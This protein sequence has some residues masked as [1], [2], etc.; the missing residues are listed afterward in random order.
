[1]QN[2]IQQLI[3]NA[4]WFFVALFMFSNVEA[5]PIK[6]TDSL[7][8]IVRNSKNDSIKVSVLNKLALHYV[9]SDLSKAKDFQEQSEQLA[10]SKKNA[11]GYNEA[12]FI[13]GG[14]FVLSGNS[15]SAYVYYKKGYDLALKNKFKPIE[16]R[17][18]NGFGLI[19]W[20]KGNHDKALNYFF[21]ALKLNESLAEEQRVNSSLFYNNIGLIYS[22][23]RLFQK[24]LGYIQK[25]YKIRL[26]DKMVREQAMSLN[27][28]GICYNNLKKTD[29][30]IAAFKKGISIARQTNNMMMYYKIIHNLGNLYADNGQYQKAI[31]LYL[32]LLEQPNSL[33][34][35]PRDLIILYGCIANTY[36]KMGDY[37]DS[38]KYASLG[39]KVVKFNP[40][41]ERWAYVLYNAVSKYYF[42]KGDIA[43]GDYY[44]IKYYTIIKNTFTEESKTTLAE[45]EAKY[46]A[47]KR[48]KLWIQ[49]KAAIEKRNLELQN[50]NA[51]YIIFFLLAIGLLVITYLLYYQQKLKNKQQKQEFKLKNAIAQVNTQNK[52]QEQRIQ[53]SRDLHDNIGSQLTFII[54]SIDS[55]KYAFEIQNSKL[56]DKL[57][58]ISDFTRSTITELRDTIWAMNK[59]EIQFE[60]L[61]ARILSFIEN[62]KIASQ[63]ISFQFNIHTESPETAFSATEGMNIY[64][65]LQEAINNAIKHAKA[66]TILVDVYQETDTFRIQISDNGK[67]FENDKVGFGNGLKNMKDRAKEINAEIS[68]TSEL[69]SGTI[70]LVSF[71]K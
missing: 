1:L 59:K 57:T 37:D 43:K 49:S 55:I 28:L 53:I 4:K 24:A 42:H 69:N 6:E 13:K 63:G 27:N 15:D 39:L 71:K 56:N 67:G 17:C 32:E 14:I 31:G 11:Y 48:E 2:G 21:K 36:S 68:I 12:I 16:V 65:I 41:L 33:N 9:S 20:N 51:Q 29:S 70:I 38:F 30:A 61:K 62:A 3:K 46:K 18:L 54:S 66:T 7:L 22:E 35:N 47:E 10:I 58:Y 19:H 50:K 40:E 45:I 26:K 60:D 5:Q 44:L 8:A 23:K 34:E 64:R 25:G 52:L